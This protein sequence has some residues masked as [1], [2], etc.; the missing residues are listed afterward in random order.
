MKKGQVT[1]FIILVVVIAA[2]GGLFFFLRSPTETTGSITRSDP[3]GSLKMYI[4]QCVRDVTVE[5]IYNLSQHGGYYRPA[6]SHTMINGFMMTNYYHKGNTV[7]PSRQEFENELCSYI[8]EHLEECTD[9]SGFAKQGY[10]IKRDSPACQATIL[11]EKTIIKVDYP[12]ELTAG[13]KVYSIDEFH[14]E[15]GIRYGHMLDISRAVAEKIA[16]NPDYRDLTFLLSFDIQPS[17]LPQEVGNED[18]EIYILQDDE[19]NKINGRRHILN[20]A[21]VYS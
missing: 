15:I 3:S 5:G 1:V 16:D 6:P 19:S 2:A 11:E 8:E 14:E 12:V 9:F 7:M 20:F 4:S 21:V 18:T 13:E 17:I 10:R